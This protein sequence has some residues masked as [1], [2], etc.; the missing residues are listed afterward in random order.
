[1]Q[2]HKAVARDVLRTEAQALE[3][4]AEALP[5][6]FDAVIELIAGCSGR[7]I[8]SGMGKSGH[9]GAKI[10]ATLAS[11]GTPAQFVHP[12][13]ASHGDLGMITADD[14]CLLLSNSGET[15]ELKDILAHCLRFN[16]ALVAL[17]SNGES[18]IAKAATYRL[19]LPKLAEACGIGMVPTTSTTVTLGMGDAL[20]VALLR[21]RAF[22]AEDFAIFH[23]GGKL[24]AQMAKVADLMHVGDEI[25]LVDADTPMG[26]ALLEMTSK[27]FGVTG[28]IKDGLLTGIITDGDLRRNMDN[29][30]GH[31]AGEVATGAV[32]TVAPDTLG[33]KALADMQARKVSVL[34][35]TQDSRPV[36]ILHL[37]DLLRA[38]VA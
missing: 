12:G 15:V 17:T 7:L 3:Y 34:M 11:T 23:P 18:T 25:P 33:A 6:D 37:H 28:V 26:D 35:I 13:E 1:M 5:E 9:I 22:T 32:V 10:T 2:S 29:L 19:T 36:G 20:A 14:V 30:M 4:L 24:G 21:K 38:G 8:V 27:G 16:V 31:T